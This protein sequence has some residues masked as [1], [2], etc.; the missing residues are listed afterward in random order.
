VSFDLWTEGWCY[1]RLRSRPVLSVESS[2]LWVVDRGVSGVS[3]LTT[4]VIALGLSLCRLLLS[5][6]LATTLCR[7]AD[8]LLSRAFLCKC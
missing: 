4:P 1:V 6:L 5:S 7:Q 2:S 8:Y 3:I